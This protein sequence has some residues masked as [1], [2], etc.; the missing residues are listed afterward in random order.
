MV[1]YPISLGLPLPTL[2]AASSVLA[3]RGAARRGAG[4]HSG[5]TQLSPRFRSASFPGSAG[6]DACS[7]LAFRSGLSD[8]PV[9]GKRVP[10]HGVHR[11]GAPRTGLLSLLPIIRARKQASTRS[12]GTSAVSRCPMRE[13]IVLILM[14]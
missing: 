4:D 13:K 14:R 10:S 9:W 1:S 8:R 6:P 7:A 2:P 12:P 5:G 3:A 11:M